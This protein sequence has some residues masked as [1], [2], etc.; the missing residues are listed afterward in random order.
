MF[1]N[2]IFLL[3]AIHGLVLSIL[4]A[5]KKINQ[6]SNRILGGL[7]V[8]FSI[9]L[10]MAT[11]LGFHIQTDFPHIIGLDFAI[12]LLYGPL[13]YLYTKTL[14]NG[15]TKLSRKDQSHFLAFVAL[16]V[17]MMPFYFSTG[18]EKIAMLNAQSGLNYGPDFITHIKIGYNLVYIPFIITLTYNY[19]KKLKDNFS[20]LEK[21]NLDWLQGFILG[22]ILLA[23]VATVLHSLGLMYGAN[24]LYTNINLL[25]ITVY[26][27]S[28]GYMGLRQPEFFTEF[29]SPAKTEETQDAK[30]AQSYSRSG[31]D[32]KAAIKLMEK[33]S[34]I[35]EEEKLYTNNELNLKEL[36]VKVG[37]STHNLTEIIN[38]YAGKNFY[39]FINSYRIEEVK[40]RIQNPNSEN[41]TILALGM[42]AGF[43]SKSSFNS[44]FKKHTGMTPSEYKRSV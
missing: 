37:I 15:Q 10:V 21:R 33:L 20:S 18:A 24:P 40:R 13:L 39:D 41:L 38:Q 27:Y 6:L 29:E 35:M 8:V 32:E 25:G 17:Y 31:L 16:L 44:V 19:R 22:G 34:K 14:I 30:S 28:I 23:A 9:D 7:M 43:N 1:I 11:I 26:V 4:L 12:T 2:T 36:A 42:E 5:T 3:G